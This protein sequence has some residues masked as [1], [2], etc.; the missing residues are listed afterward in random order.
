M[1]KN[2]VLGIISLGFLGYSSININADEQTIVEYNVGS[3]YVLEIPSKVTLND[4]SNT[5][6][7][8]KTVSHNLSPTEFV[9]V[10][11]EE[12]LTS[13]SEISLSRYMDPSTTITTSITS[14]GAKIPM[15]NPEIDIFDSKNEQNYTIA[16]LFM[17]PL[18]G[19]YKS[20]KY[21][22]TLTFGSEII[23]RD[24]PENL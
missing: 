16:T 18:D 10:S 3:E 22:T 21:S 7:D 12:G 9:R 4:Y 20:G 14:N 5:Y 15:D 1:R 2:L 8:I 19:N 17:A 6:I 24:V 23:D 13:D 11:L